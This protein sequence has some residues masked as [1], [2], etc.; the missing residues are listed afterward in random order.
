MANIMKML[1]ILQTHHYFLFVVE[2]VGFKIFVATDNT[3]KPEDLV[4]IIEEAIQVR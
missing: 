2:N 3:V 4:F 1:G